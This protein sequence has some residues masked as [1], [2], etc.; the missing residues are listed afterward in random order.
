[1]NV[2]GP[3]TLAYDLSLPT[4]VFRFQNFPGLGPE[5]PSPHR[6]FPRESHLAALDR[7]PADRATPRCGRADGGGVACSRTKLHSFL[8][9][10]SGFD[11]YILAGM[12]PAAYMSL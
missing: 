10:M 12:S 6:Y 9:S 5:K 11:L 7:L 4:Q 8:S 2:K 1:M 3:E